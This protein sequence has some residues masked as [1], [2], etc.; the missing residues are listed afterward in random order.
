MQA[1]YQGELPLA[2]ARGLLSTSL[3][4][5][6]IIPCP[7][8]E[9]KHEW[10]KFYERAN[11]QVAT[12]KN[13]LSE[14]EKRNSSGTTRE[15]IKQYIDSVV[16]IITPLF[17]MPYKG[18]RHHFGGSRISVRD[19]RIRKIKL[20][21]NFDGWSTWRLVCKKNKDGV[22]ESYVR[23]D[24]WLRSIISKKGIDKFIKK[25]SKR[26]YEEINERIS[27]LNQSLDD[28]INYLPK[29]FIEKIG[30]L[31][32]S[33]KD[34]KSEE[35]KLFSL[36]EGLAKIEKNIKA[37]VSELKK[38][39]FYEEGLVLSFDELLDAGVAPRIRPEKLER[40]VIER[41][42][43]RDQ[44]LPQLMKELY[45]KNPESLH[46]LL[47]VL[48]AEMAKELSNLGAVPLSNVCS[49]LS[50]FKRCGL[51]AEEYGKKIVNFVKNEQ[52]KK[53]KETNRLL[54]DIKE[55]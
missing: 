42:R 18:K 17:G 43:K 10:N 28:L 55:I 46:S 25:L 3:K 21:Y 2:F 27:L 13:S 50:Y 36:S 41:F 6:P 8:E 26:D 35:K 12:L 31:E 29:P 44:R 23:S 24:G 20:N 22:L 19:K 48:E 39:C 9:L 49:D 53:R 38:H 5:F 15:L 54:R 7:M 45:N 51:P 1:E 52:R 33:L 14:L 47:A 34:K 16:N 37:K 30:E 4:A 40:P 32:G 11:E